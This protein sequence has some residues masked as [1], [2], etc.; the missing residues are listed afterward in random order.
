MWPTE[1][2]GRIR[3]SYVNARFAQY[4]DEL[5]L[6]PV[7]SIHGLRRSYV[8]HLI[9]DGWDARFVKVQCGHSVAHLRQL[10][11][12]AGMFSTTDRRQDDIDQP[13]HFHGEE[14]RW[15]L[16]PRLL[17]EKGQRQHLRVAACLVLLYA[18]PAARIVTLTRD[19]IHTTVHDLVTLR[20]GD[21][22]IASPPPLDVLLN[23]L[24]L[25]GPK[26]RRRPPAQADWLFPGRHAGQHLHPASLTHRLRALEVDPRANRNTALLQLAAEIPAPVLATSSASTSW[27]PSNWA[28]EAAG[29]WTN[30]AASRATT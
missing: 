12:K 28:A 29:D 4:R 10:M 19:H 20:L 17:H 11:A 2:G 3:T 25:H 30:Y 1:R 24:P 26:G 27:P 15:E 16:A 22:G 23:L 6:D 9:E 8:T 7:L 13:K 21:T 5:G 18:Q 14:Q